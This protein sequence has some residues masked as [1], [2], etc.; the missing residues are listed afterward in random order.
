MPNSINIPKRSI[1]SHRKSVHRSRTG[2][3]VSGATSNGRVTTKTI[4]KKRTRLN[5]RNS[6]YIVKQFGDSEIGASGTTVVNP[7]TG[8]RHS[9][10]V[11]KL[12]LEAISQVNAAKAAE[13]AEQAGD[14]EALS[15]T[16]RKIRA[17][18]EQARIANQAAAMLA[19]GLELEDDAMDIELSGN[20][21]TLGKPR[22]F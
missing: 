11:E 7:D 4:S 12:L 21:T 17:K 19:S 16:Q 20:G 14:D 9:K 5:V 8:K 3:P 1:K 6:H 15:K 10:V 22:V 13:E 2:R 18:R